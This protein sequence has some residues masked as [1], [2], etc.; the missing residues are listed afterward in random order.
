MKCKTKYELRTFR[1]LKLRIITGILRYI[2]GLLC[3]IKLHRNIFVNYF[4]SGIKQ[5]HDF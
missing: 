5:G 3:K 4:T 1:E 2:S